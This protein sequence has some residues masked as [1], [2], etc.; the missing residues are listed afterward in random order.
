MVALTEKQKVKL[1]EHAKHHTK[2][3]IA[4]MKKYMKNGKSFSKSH[5]MVKKKS[6]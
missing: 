5:M 1:K 4:D 3:H 2:K 6:Y